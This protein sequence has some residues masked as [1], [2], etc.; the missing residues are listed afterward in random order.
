MK[1]DTKTWGDGPDL[2]LIHGW[3]M[4]AQ[5]WGE[6]GERLGREWHVT[7]VN[8]PGHGGA[9]RLDEPFTAAAVAKALTAVAPAEAVWLGWSLGG[10]L[11]LEATALGARP[12]GI[13]VLAGTPRF[14]A[15]PDWPWGVAS[16]AL[17]AVET[18]LDSDP[19]RALMRFVQLLATGGSGARRAARDLLARLASGPAP[20][21]ACLAQG[22]T[23]LRE[24]DARD[25]LR[26]LNCPSLWLGGNSDPLIPARALS[27]SASLSGGSCR[28]LEGAGH[29]PFMTHP[30]AVAEAL[31]GWWNE[32]HERE[33]LHHR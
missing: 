24:T 11:A 2:F 21:P 3:G 28:I 33:P 13:A 29:L 7:A 15:G 26:A 9:P 27:E 6:F 8:L 14:V 12:R 18:Q 17:A 5:V 10:L 1:Q 25:R 23:V 31:S 20:D 30:E 4:S 19:G 16:Q 22:L 32:S